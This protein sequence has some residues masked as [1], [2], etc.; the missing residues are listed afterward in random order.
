M[1]TTNLDHAR[2]RRGA[3]EQIGERTVSRLYE[4][5][6]DP[7]PMYGEDQRLEAT[8]RRRPSPRPTGS[9]A[10]LAYGEAR[11]GGRGFAS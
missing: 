3:G 11:A 7:K 9:A 8:L 4:I 1:L 10:S 5:C 6:G 2:G